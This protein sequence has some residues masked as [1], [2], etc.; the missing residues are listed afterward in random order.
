MR[1]LNNC[2]LWMN[3]WDTQVVCIDGLYGGGGGGRGR[4]S[5]SPLMFVS[6]KCLLTVWKKTKETHNHNLMM[7]KPMR[8][9]RWADWTEFS[10]CPRTSVLTGLSSVHCQGRVGEGLHLLHL[11]VLKCRGA[12]DFRRDR[13]RL[14]HHSSSLQN[15]TSHFVDVWLLNAVLNQR[16]YNLYFFKAEPGRY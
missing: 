13:K 5:W 14:S 10:W 8:P 7:Q 2:T 1:K 15:K 3:L 11:P 9:N 6:M 12:H 4:G 16:Q